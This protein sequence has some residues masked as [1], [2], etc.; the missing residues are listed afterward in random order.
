[1]P[2]CLYDISS[3]SQLEEAAKSL[4]ATLNPGDVLALRGALGAGKT[5]F[6]QALGSALGI[7]QT[8]NSPTFVLI[9]RYVTGR[10]P[11]VHCDFYRLGA[12]NASQLEP[13]LT[14]ILNEGH[15]IVVA[16]W[17]ELAD[18]LQPAITHWLLFEHHDHHNGA[19]TLSITEVSS[20]QTL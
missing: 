8:I 20:L 9:Q 16:E 18:F 4:A 6:T 11:L 7:S 15:S 1:M 3:L 14:D 12:E 13:E 10:L 2:S 19:R 5:T 17:A